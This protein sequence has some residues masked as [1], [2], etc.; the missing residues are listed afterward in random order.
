M[1]VIVIGAGVVGLSVA[2]A[3]AA[4]GASV[5]VLDGR[6]PGE[7]ATRASAGILAPRIEA[8]TDAQLT[9]GLASL[10]RYDAFVAGL[11]AETGRPVEYDRSGTLHVAYGDTEAEELS[12]LF[13]QLTRDGGDATLLTGQAAR[14]REPELADGVRAG[15]EIGGQGHVGVADL[16]SALLAACAALGVRVE[17]RAVD[18]VDD[19]G[20]RPIV[21]TAGEVV[22]ADAVVVAAGAWTGRL[23][24]GPGDRDAP[25]RVK[26]IRGQLLHLRMPSPP[27]SRVT[28]GS[29]CY[30][31]PWRDGSVLAGATVEDVGF[32]ERA[33][34]AGVRQLLEAATS[35][36]PGLA[37][38]GLC[39]VRVGLRPATGDELP[40]IGASATMP[41]VFYATGHYR[42]GVLLAPLT[43]A[44]VAD[45]ILD[46][47]SHPELRLTSPSRLGL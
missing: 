30:L 9:L 7:G 4:R 24:A 34:V 5:L 15:L 35:I 22:G 23:F 10:A 20:G 42:T 47:R 11:R 45:L 27:L 6:A 44:L 3:L 40:L 31:V 18:G 33:T 29:A 25:E 14:S 39:D 17:R 43:A 19:E 26:P 8:H 21:R 1:N 28:W 36:V 46:G 41:G 2:H 16:V 32:D 12:A 38:A 13:V 37:T